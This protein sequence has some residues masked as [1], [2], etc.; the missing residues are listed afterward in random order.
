MMVMM[1]VFW[2]DKPLI[3]LEMTE[4]VSSNAVDE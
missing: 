2:V 1:V 4:L 3:V